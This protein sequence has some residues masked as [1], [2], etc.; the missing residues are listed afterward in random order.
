M[1]SDPHAAAVAR[2]FELTQIDYGRVDYGLLDGAVQVWEINTNPMI[3]ALPQ[4]IA[5]LRLPGQQWAA[6]QINAAFEGI[7]TEPAGEPVFVAVPAEARRG[8]G[9]S[10]A[11]RLA[12]L[13]RRWWIRRRNGRIWRF[14]T[15]WARP[16]PAPS[17]HA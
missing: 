12:S 2:I 8:L 5:P 10:V 7:D 3:T 4:N 16:A 11:R 9:R 1:A 6:E 15:G 14:L 13:A 17:E